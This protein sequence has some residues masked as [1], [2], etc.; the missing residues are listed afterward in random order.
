MLPIKNL[1]GSFMKKRSR[2][3]SLRA[4][5]RRVMS[6]FHGRFH[7]AFFIWR[8]AEEQEWLDAAPVGR[9]FGSPDYERLEVLDCYSYGVITSAQAMRRLGLDN[10]DTL[11][12]QMLDAGISIPAPGAAPALKGLFADQVCRTASIDAMNKAVMAAVTAEFNRGNPELPAQFVDDI[13][14]STEELK[15]GHVTTFKFGKSEP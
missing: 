5:N 12:A 3:S 15:A 13:M 7:C 10:L 6:L 9:E 8:T 2:R 1:S 14:Q 11:H 4:I